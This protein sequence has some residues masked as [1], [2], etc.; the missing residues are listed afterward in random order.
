MRKVRARTGRRL[1]GDN[2]KGYKWIL[3]T[4]LK[5]DTDIYSSKGYVR[6]FTNDWFVKENF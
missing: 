3:A 5:P 1:N 6:Y 4:E 2:L